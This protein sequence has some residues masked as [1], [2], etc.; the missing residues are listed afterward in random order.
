MLTA[1]KPKKGPCENCGGAGGKRRRLRRGDTATYVLC[2][3][4]ARKM[5]ARHT[6]AKKARHAHGGKPGRL[7]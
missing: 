2:G 7:V 3:E 6:T 1:N 5:G 4:C